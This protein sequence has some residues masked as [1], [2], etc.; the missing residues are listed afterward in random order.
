M[1]R[2]KILL[3]LCFCLRLLLSVRTCFFRSEGKE[4]PNNVI[5][6]T[7]RLRIGNPA[8][9]DIFLE[10]IGVKDDIGRLGRYMRIQWNVTQCCD[11]IKIKNLILNGAGVI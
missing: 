11:K 1:H 8:D 4:N 7:N 9:T 6:S 10:I 5:F 3:A 2:I